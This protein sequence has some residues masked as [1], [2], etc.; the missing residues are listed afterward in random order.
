MSDTYRQTSFPDEELDQWDPE[1]KWL[2]RQARFRLDAELIR[3]NALAV[4]G[5]LSNK[6]GGR[7]V[8]PYQ[9]DGYWANINTFGV[10]G[11][12]TTWSAEEDQEQY[13]RGLYTYWKRSFLHPSM[14]AFDAPT[15]QESEAQRSVSNT[16]SQ[17]LVLLNDPTYVEAARVFA[18]R[19]LKEGGAT[20][21]EQIQW[22]YRQAL[23]RDARPRE[24]ELL[25]DLY[26]SQLDEYQVDEEGAI[27]L[28]QVGIAPSEE[29]ESPAH[30]AAATA[31][32]RALFN[33]HEMITRN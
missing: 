26:Q 1:N 22:A 30:N 32:A 15:R 21:D 14:L 28:L 7:S 31:V 18:G 25:R 10:Q 17:A 29:A 3:D 6:I 5:L 12:G 9:P 19:M 8:Q 33:L 13:R 4:S 2:A 11:P 20:F 16:P 27:K 24:V 23:S